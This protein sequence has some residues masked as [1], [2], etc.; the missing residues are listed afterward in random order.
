MQPVS[1][2]Y[3]RFIA[4]NLP[5]LSEGL[6]DALETTSPVV[7]VRVNRR[8][9]LEGSLSPVLACAASDPVPWCPAGFY[10][11]QRPDFTHDPAMHQG[12]YYVQ[13]A[14][15]MVLGHVVGHVAGLLGGGAASLRYL[16]ACAAP[17]GKTTAAID[18]LPA[19]A[20]V[21]ANEF[22]FRRA[23]VLKEN[24]E[25]WG[26]P[27]VAISRGDTARF[28]RLG[29]WF[30]IIAADVPCSG[31]GMMRKD[32][33]ARTQWTPALVAECA[34]RQ[35]EI[36]ENLW[37]AL[38][39]GGFFIY[40]TCTFNRIENE[41]MVERMERELG[42]IRVEVPLPA[43]GS[44]IVAG[45]GMMRFLPG[46]VRGEGLFMSVLRKP[47][48]YEPR[49]PVEVSG[50]KATKQA[51]GWNHMPKGCSNKK[52]KADA[53]AVLPAQASGMLSEWLDG[54]FVAL[55]GRDGETVEAVVRRYE[56]LFRELDNA[57][58]LIM[59]GV[60]AGRM[61]G[62]K[63]VPAQGLALSQALLAGAFPQ[64]DVDRDTALSFLR[65]E[66]L[67]GFDAPRGWVLL[68]HGGLPLGFV[69]NL[70]NRANNPYP[71][72]WRILH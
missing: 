42:A 24:V 63:L 18:A 13:D 33:T 52:G 54:D 67:G 44:G 31:E 57:L 65:R 69:N 39:P 60:D 26:H 49:T 62:G 58:D 59:R 27:H 10:L 40:S 9:S 72:P 7:S 28:R 3:R 34:A 15:S 32:E 25:K 2:D 51:A 4:D 14:S 22:D 8:R 20:L 5:A 6:V 35:W 53:C 64:V 43:D 12:A 1:N 17:G 70:G 68:T 29:G 66:S 41:Q 16:D 11:P 48:E 47:G 30:D 50:R 46:R 19:D 21:V 37:P 38:A 55:P 56:P 23:E 61:K 45:R 71:S 36:V